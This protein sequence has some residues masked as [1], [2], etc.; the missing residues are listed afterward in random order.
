MRTARSLPTGTVVAYNF[1][2]SG[3]GTTVLPKE[4]AELERREVD[5]GRV[6]L[7]SVMTTLA[8]GSVAVATFSNCTW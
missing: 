8:A 2:P 1:R 5:L 4:I 7:W 6:E 3:T